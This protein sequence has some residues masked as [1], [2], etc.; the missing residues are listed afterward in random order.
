MKQIQFVQSRYGGQR[1]QKQLTHPRLRAG[2][3][4]SELSQLWWE[5]G[6]ELG[7]RPSALL[8]HESFSS[9]AF[10]STSSAVSCG[11][12]LSCD[13]CARYSKEE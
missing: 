1:V 11:R 9:A 2:H 10:S 5:G 4:Q 8:G 13:C 7:Q 3:A 6:L 12:W